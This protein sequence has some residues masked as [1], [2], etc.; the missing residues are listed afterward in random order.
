MSNPLRFDDP[1]EDAAPPRWSA[2]GL[3]ARL[4]FAIALPA[5]VGGLVASLI[6]WDEGRWPGFAIAALVTALGAWVWIDVTATRRLQ[7]VARALAPG[8]DAPALAP[9]GGLSAFVEAAFA[10]RARERELERGVARLELVRKGLAELSARAAEWAETECAPG[11]ETG[12]APE[13]LAPLVMRLALAASRLEQRAAAARAVAGQVRETVAEAGAQAGLLAAAAERQ[14]VEAGSLLGVLR[15]LERWSG[16]LAQGVAG[17]AV[18]LAGDQADAEAARDASGAWARGAAMQMEVLERAAE[19]LRAASHDL[20]RLHEEAQVAALESAHAALAGDTLPAEDRVRL[21]DALSALV[22]ATRAA[23]ARTH[24]LEERAHADLARAHEE[25][26]ALNARGPAPTGAG[27][28]SRPGDPA[29]IARRALERMHENVRDAI[30]RGERLVQQA[31]R[32]S[33]EAQRTGE[34]VIA[35]VD[36][37]DGLAARLA[38]AAPPEVAAMVSPEVAPAPDPALKLAGDGTPDD[39]TSAPARPLRVLGP[40]D[41]LPDDENWSHG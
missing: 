37:V 13:E 15:G 1:A 26:G 7:R 11:F 3:R 30:A 20:A 38:D 29:L 40:E 34:D 21:V 10:A 41:L 5:L 36:E 39:A 28:A 35:A 12:A 32:T 9:G 16:E 23:Q 27:G 8:S 2:R 33:S 14:F 19:R 4:A 22:R 18:A 25:Y 24:E 17:L 31:E 6:P